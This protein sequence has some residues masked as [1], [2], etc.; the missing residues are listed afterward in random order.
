M[1]VI[2]TRQRIMRVVFS[3]KEW[4]QLCIEAEQEAKYVEV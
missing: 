1:G 4:G 3:P 2:Q